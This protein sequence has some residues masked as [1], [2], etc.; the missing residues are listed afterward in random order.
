M[1]ARK[2]DIIA[3]INKMVNVFNE[4]NKMI[5]ESNKQQKTEKEISYLIKN[6]NEIQEDCRKIEEKVSSAKEFASEIDLVLE[7]ILDPAI[8]EIKD[9]YSY[10]N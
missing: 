4:N 1:Q 9:K 3:L 10:K 7:S 2:K 5:K 6:N 8:Q